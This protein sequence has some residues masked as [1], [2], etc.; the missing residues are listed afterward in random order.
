M[1]ELV[2]ARRVGAPVAT[3]DLLGDLVEADAAEP[4]HRAGEVLVDQLVAEADRLEDLRARYDATVEMPIFDITF[5]T[6]LP[7]ALM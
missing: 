1:G 2:G 4:R 7:A 6:P 3:R 5:S